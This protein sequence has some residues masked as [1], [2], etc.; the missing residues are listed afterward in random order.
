MTKQFLTS[1]G[2][3]ARQYYSGEYI[4]KEGSLPSYLYYIIKGKVKLSS[5][6]KYGKEVLFNILF[7]EQYFGV[8]LLFIDKAYPMDAVALADSTIMRLCKKKFI[9][10]LEIYPYLYFDICGNLSESIYYQYFMIKNI[11]SLGAADRVIGI[12]DYLKSLNEHTTPFSFKVPLTRKQIACFTG[13]SVETVIR[14][15]KILEKESKVKIENK[16]ILY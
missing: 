11:S 15:I 6:D 10:I 3:E 7:P 16:K 1:V 5:L 9:K 8:A 14:T 4:F 13:L 2:A 12:L